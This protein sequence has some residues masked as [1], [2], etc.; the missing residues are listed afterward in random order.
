MTTTR[1][2]I[3]ALV[4][5]AMISVTGAMAVSATLAAK[6]AHAFAGESGTGKTITAGY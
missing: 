6:H 3:A 1:K 2:R 5:A 4:L